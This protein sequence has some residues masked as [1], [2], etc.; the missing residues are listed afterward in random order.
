MVRRRKISAFSIITGA[1]VLFVI[2]I[3]VMT[4]SWGVLASFKPARELVTYPPM[5]FNF[6]ASLENYEAVFRGGFLGGVANSGLYGLGAAAVVILGGS[7]AAFG[8]GRFEF[9]GREALFMIFVAGIP[10]AMGAAAML[11]PNFVMFASLGITNKWFTLPIIY[12]AHMLPL[13]VWIIRGAMD[14]VPKELDEAAYVDG[15]SSL[16]VLWKIVFPLCKPSLA[17]VAILVFIYAWNEFVAGATMVDATHLKPIQPLLYQFVGF[18]GRD[19]GPLTAGATIAM[20]PILVIYAFFGR[21]LVSGL[22][23]GATKG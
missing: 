6:S 3:N 1:L 12:A 15:A 14:A 7:M 2:A 19:W 16:T 20:L 18:F 5:L 4:V 22:T 23:H 8:L 13:A 11:I 9:R 17:A 21:Y 10:L